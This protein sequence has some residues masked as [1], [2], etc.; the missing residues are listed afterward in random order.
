MLVVEGSGRTADTM[1]AALHEDSKDKRAA[2][3]AASGSCRPSTL[4]LAR[5]PWPV[6]SRGPHHQPGGAA[7]LQVL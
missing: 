4:A 3:L 7:R 5:M 6:P 1:A 2:D